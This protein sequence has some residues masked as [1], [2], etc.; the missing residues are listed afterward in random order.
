[1]CVGARGLI[2]EKNKNSD[3]MIKIKKIFRV[4]L[5]WQIMI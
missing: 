4:I 3:N 1:M 2:K 5:R